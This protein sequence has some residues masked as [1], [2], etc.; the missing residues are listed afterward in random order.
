MQNAILTLIIYNLNPNPNTNPG[1]DSRRHPF[2]EARYLTLTL[3][4]EA[5]ASDKVAHV[6]AGSDTNALKEAVVRLAA[7]LDGAN[8]RVMV[9][10]VQSQKGKNS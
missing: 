9:V 3:F 4:G 6:V 7:E 5:N 2:L 10:E 1:F 8:A